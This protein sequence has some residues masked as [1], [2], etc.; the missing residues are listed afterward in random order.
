M[1]WKSKLPALENL[2]ISR[3]INPEGFREIKRSS[4]HH[5]SDTSEGGYRQSSYLR[6][7]DDQEKI[8]CV[9]LIGK[10]R[11]SPLKY[12]SI[13]RLELIAATLSV[14]VSLFLRRELEIPINKEYFRT[15]SKVVLGY[16][17]NN[18]I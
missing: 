15:Y 16:I 17:S 1:E 13:P 8:Q 9:L 14:K 11:V 2:A 18:R 12:I 5:F 6:L 3:C 10:S 7:Q 4:I